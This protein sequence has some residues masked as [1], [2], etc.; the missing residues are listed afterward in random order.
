MQ[1]L[2]MTST[3]QS[4][5][6]PEPPAFTLQ[7]LTVIRSIV[8]LGT[9]RGAWYEEELEDVGKIAKRIIRVL[10]HAEQGNK[11]GWQPSAVEDQKSQD[12]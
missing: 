12:K 4:S 9:L 8:K 6:A 1:L 2:Q 7:E 10:A 5:Q 11:L 3:T